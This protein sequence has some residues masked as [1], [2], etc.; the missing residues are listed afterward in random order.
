MRRDVG[1]R[2]KLI[3][4]AT[5]G[6]IANTL[7]GRVAVEE[8]IADIEA[9]HPSVRVHDRY[10]IE[11]MDVERAGAETFDPSTW[12]KIRDAV[13]HACDRADVDGV[14][15]THGT[16]TVE[17]TAYYLHLTVDT[18]KPLVLTCAQRKHATVGNDGD[19]N[20]LDAL[21]AAATAEL[22]GEGAVLVANEEIHS[23]R[24]VVKTSKRPDGFT[25]PSL[26]PL[27]FVDEDRVSLY[28][29]QRRRHTSR[30]AFARQE[31]H[32][33]PRIDIISTHPGASADLVLAAGESGTQGVVMHGY[34]FGG[35][36][37]AAQHD[38]LLKLAGGGIPVIFVSRGR[39]GR[40]PLQGHDDPFVRG[41]N[42]V[43][44]KAHVLATTAIAAGLTEPAALQ[45]VFDEH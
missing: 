34:A 9:Q 43:S 41:D 14:V 28:R 39:E 27:G 10:D 3:I 21:R 36:P 15:V 18:D 44:S 7:S 8:V 35:K 25:S 17:E 19:H 16:Y 6:T 23:A 2:P 1:H 30:S 20:L 26:G 40:I 38:A 24:E 42:L 5:G 22:G 45:Q 31:A 37:N 32:P 11:I 33:L 12:V 13:Q 4:A 29:S